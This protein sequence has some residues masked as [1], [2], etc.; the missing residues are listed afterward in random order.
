MTQ[1]LSQ[2]RKF[3]IAKSTPPM[4]PFVPRAPAR[5]LSPPIA[6]TRHHSPPVDL[7]TS[8]AASLAA[9]QAG[10]RQAID[11]LYRSESGRV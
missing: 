4:M 3:S 11:P 2:Q 1:T 8:T 7:A 9:L 5:R 10:D 6:A